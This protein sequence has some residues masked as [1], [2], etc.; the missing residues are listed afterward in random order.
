MLEGHKCHYYLCSYQQRTG[1][2]RLPFLVPANAA[3]LRNLGPLC[4]IVL[5]YRKCGWLLTPSIHWVSCVRLP[6]PVFIFSAFCLHL[7]IG[8]FFLNRHPKRKKKDGTVSAMAIL[9]TAL[10]SIQRYICRHEGFCLAQ[11]ANLHVF[12]FS[13]LL[14]ASRRDFF[15]SQTKKRPQSISN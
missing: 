9:T 7:L 8:I 13:S 2:H 11:P 4:T 10:L 14:L 15:L 3:V 12:Q 1:G 5:S 6:H